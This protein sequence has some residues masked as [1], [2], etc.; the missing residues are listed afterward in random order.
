MYF[1]I[2]ASYHRSNAAAASPIKK[3]KQHGKTVLYGVPFDIPSHARGAPGLT[4]TT[5]AQHAAK[6]DGCGCYVNR[7]G[8]N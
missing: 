5:I 3:S 7:S 2:K 6:K 4:M 8:C 1:N